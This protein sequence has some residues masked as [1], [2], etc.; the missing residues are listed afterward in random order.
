METYITTTLCHFK[1]NKGKRKKTKGNYTKG[2]Q[3]QKITKK[4]IP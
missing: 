2:K 3:E 1:K 4:R